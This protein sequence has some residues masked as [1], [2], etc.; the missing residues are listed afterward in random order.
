[1]PFNMFWSI[2]T[3]FHSFFLEFCVLWR[4]N[5]SFGDRLSWSR[6]EP[7]NHHL[8]LEFRKTLARINSAGLQCFFMLLAL[9]SC[10]VNCSL[11]YCKF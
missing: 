10:N 2:Y 3:T 4:E 9:S 8:D 6:L 1:M 7:D 11:V 5:L